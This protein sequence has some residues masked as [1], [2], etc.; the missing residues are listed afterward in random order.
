MG[1]SKEYSPRRRGRVIKGL[2]MGDMKRQVAFEEDMK[3]DSV[4][5]TWQIS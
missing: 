2:E 5:Y 3:I 4:K 1:L